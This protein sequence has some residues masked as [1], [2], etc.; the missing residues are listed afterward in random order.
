MRDPSADGELAGIM[1][2]S[3]FLPQDSPSYWT[4]YWEVDDVRATVD[5]VKA[6]GGSVVAE[7]G[8]TPYGCL[9]GVAD[10]AGAQFKLRTPPG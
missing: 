1:D 5:K 7:P 6:L 3:G 2:A 9:A 8:D 4:V 10:P